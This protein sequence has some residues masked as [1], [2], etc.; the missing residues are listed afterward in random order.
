MLGSMT[1]KKDGITTVIAGTATIVSDARLNRLIVQGTTEDVAVIDEY[2]KIVDKGSSITDVETFGRSH[3]VELQYTKATEVAEMLKQAFGNRIASG[4]ST[5]P[6][7]QRPGEAASGVRPVTRANVAMA[8][9]PPLVM[10][11]K[12][13]LV[14]VSRR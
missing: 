14:V 1:T 13:P 10:S 4:G 9:K 2:M 5:P 3:V 11:R 6:Q 12:S 8:T 7:N